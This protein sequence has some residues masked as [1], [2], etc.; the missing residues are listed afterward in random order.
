M[1]IVEVVLHT[2]ITKYL[3]VVNLLNYG[4]KISNFFSVYLYKYMH[5]FC[6]QSIQNPALKNGN[7]VKLKII[8]LPT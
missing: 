6:Y 8:T 2:M 5:F 3:T 4:D 1:S 7:E